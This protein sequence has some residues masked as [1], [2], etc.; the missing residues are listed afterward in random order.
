MRTEVVHYMVER[1][2]QVLHQRHFRAGFVIERHHLVKY[3]EVTCLLYICNGSEDQPHRI[4]VETAS[5]I[6]VS[7]LCQ[8]LVLVV[9]ASVRELCR[10]YVYDTLTRSFRYLVH[11]SHEVLVG[12]AEAHSAADAA[13]EER[14]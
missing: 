13:L 4:V 1:N 2:A 12:I 5:D 7:T 6:V 9:A 14:G 10:C 8:R 3:A 11:K